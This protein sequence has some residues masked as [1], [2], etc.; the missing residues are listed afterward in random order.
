LRCWARG[1]DGAS[2]SDS[3][4]G[5]LRWRSMCCSSC[6][7]S[8]LFFDG[9]ISCTSQGFIMNIPHRQFARLTASWSIRA[10]VTTDVG[11]LRAG[12]CRLDSA[13]C[14]RG[15]GLKRR[16]FITL[17][18]GAAAAWPLAALA[19]QAEAPAQR[20][21]MALVGLLSSAQLDD[22]QI[23]AIRRGLKD[24]GYI[25]GLNVAIK[26]RSADSRFDRLPALAADLVSDSV[27]AI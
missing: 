11:D 18:G 6:P 20:S 3:R 21:V 17:L 10:R 15:D 5:N 24:A 13:A 19:R 25:E 22:R 9:S 2:S 27:D 23:T 12:V 26:Y 1:S 8:A 4:I 7:E 14:G 16:D